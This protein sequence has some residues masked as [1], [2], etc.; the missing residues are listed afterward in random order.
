M[1]KSN[2]FVITML[3]LLLLA[4]C[5]KSESEIQA[6][7]A[8]AENASLRDEKAKKIRQE[9][10]TLNDR[11]RALR[12]A[13]QIE[14]QNEDEKSKED[15]LAILEQFEQHNAKQ[16]KSLDSLQDVIEKEV[17]LLSQFTKVEINALRNDL[18]QNIEVVS[19]LQKQMQTLKGNQVSL[20]R[21]T[22]NLEKELIAKDGIIAK[23][24]EERKRKQDELDLIHAKIRKYEERVV[25]AEERIKT[26]ERE[27]E[28]AIKEA[29]MQAARM[30]MENGNNYFKAAQEQKTLLGVGKDTKKELYAKAYEYF[31]KAYAT[32][33]MPEANNKICI[34]E[35]DKDVLK[36]ITSKKICK[37]GR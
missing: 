28:A 17:P 9:L 31:Q 10:D 20:K 32:G 3:S 23:I 25:A 6:Q 12:Q 11:I 16:Q 1:K 19:S 34:M 8:F 36:F 21:E 5:N 26:A 35:T 29:K 15:A 27:T 2:L 30:Y 13:F 18:S 37:G 33:L 14:L 24:K 4:S 7:Q 22:Q